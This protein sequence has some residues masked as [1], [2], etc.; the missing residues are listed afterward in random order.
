MAKL[1]KERE[2][3]TGIEYTKEYVSISR[4]ILK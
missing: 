2:L 4:A 1:I 3:I